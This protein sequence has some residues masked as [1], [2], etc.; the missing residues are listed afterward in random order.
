ML[1]L[2]SDYSNILTQEEISN[3]TEI[4]RY[5][6]INEPISERCPISYIEFT[7]DVNVSRIKHCQHTFDTNSLT[8]WLTRKNTC[9]VCRYDLKN[10]GRTTNTLNENISSSSQQDASG[11]YYVNDNGYETYYYISRR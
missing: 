11:N 10:Y 1:S 9:P 6:D 5:G 2:P 3:S 7:P 4:I 8:E